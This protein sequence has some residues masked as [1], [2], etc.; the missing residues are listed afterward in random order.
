[1][2]NVC[3]FFGGVFLSFLALH[4][5]EGNEHLLHADASV[6]EGVLVVL[7]VV[8]IVVGVGKEILSCGEYIGGTEVGAG[9]TGL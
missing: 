3:F 5:D 4:R 1:M 6:L 8:V 2:V 7:H 9:Q